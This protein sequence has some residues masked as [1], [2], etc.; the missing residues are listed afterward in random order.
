MLAGCSDSFL[1]RA[2][3]GAY[4]DATFYTSDEA[5]EA[6]TAPLY[7]RA[8]FDYNNAYLEAWQTYNDYYATL[9][10]DH[11]NGNILKD[12]YTNEEEVDAVELAEVYRGEL[13]NFIS[14][15]S[16][17]LFGTET[18]YVEARLVDLTVDEIKDEISADYMELVPDADFVPFTHINNN[19]YRYG[20]VGT[21]AYLQALIDIAKA[22]LE[23][24]EAIAAL[25]A[26]L[27][28]HLADVNAIIAKAGE[29]AASAEWAYTQADEA[30]QAKFADIDKK[31]EEAEALKYAVKP[32]IDKVDAAIETYLSYEN[33]D[34]ETLADLKKTLNEALVEAEGEMYD[35]E[36][37]LLKAQDRQKKYANEEANAVTIAQ[38]DLE[39][40]ENDLQ[41]AQD[42]LTAA[43]EALLAEIDR[44]S[45]QNEEVAE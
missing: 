2:P 17:E 28:E 1:D 16:E 15:L 40:A 21:A 12:A 36:T 23:N 22:T 44:I 35:A 27:N 39:E 18:R 4:V 43:N 13:K 11:F 8:W 32:V 34:A 24:E 10:L 6:A 20:M 42:E 37:D 3:E 7:N 25:K 14:R 33:K 38:E 9:K 19:L 31:I 26:E 30:L 5:L 41:E 29:D 45:E